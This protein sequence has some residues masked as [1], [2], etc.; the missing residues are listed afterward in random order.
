MKPFLYFFE[1]LFFSTTLFSE[2]KN[3]DFVKADA[4]VAAAEEKIKKPVYY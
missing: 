1:G 2:M 3:I 4:K